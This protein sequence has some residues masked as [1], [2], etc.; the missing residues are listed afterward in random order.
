MTVEDRDKNQDH[1]IPHRKDPLPSGEHKARSVRALFDAIAQ[2]YD[3]VN[4]VM[5]FGLDRRWRL[6]ALSSLQLG[7]DALV[8]DLACGTGDFLELISQQGHR[9]IGFDF[10]KAM[11]ETAQRRLQLGPDSDT[12]ISVIQADVTALPVPTAIFDGVTCGFALRNFV[13][14]QD[15]FT[16]LARVVKPG[17]TIALVDVSRPHSKLLRKGFDF[18]FNHIVPVIGSVL[19]NRDA[20]SYLPRSLSYLPDKERLCEMVEE[21]GFTAVEHR[22]LSGGLVQLIS[23][24]R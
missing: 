8:A 15:F 13:D 4:T 11:L 2:R 6:R 14:L 9:V 12:G 24:R 17:G 5:T 22:Q 1:L 16:E 18:Y 7:S 23:A 20:Y 10:S 3:L 21:A 19:S